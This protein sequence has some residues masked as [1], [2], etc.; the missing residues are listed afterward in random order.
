MYLAFIHVVRPR[1]ADDTFRAVANTLARDRCRLAGVMPLPAVQDDRHRCDQDLVDLSS[2]RRL[3]IHQALGRGSTG[4]RLDADALEAIVAAVGQQMEVQRPEILIVNR[5]GKL[6]ATGR[7]FCPLIARALDLEIPVLVGVNDLNRAAFDAFASG[8]ALE[9]PDQP[10][11][12][13]EWVEPLLQ[14][15]AV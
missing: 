13:L 3:S 7:G 9:L 8:L 15:V 14:G 1:A 6:E 12:V 2:G 11:P 5:F 4:C 10:G